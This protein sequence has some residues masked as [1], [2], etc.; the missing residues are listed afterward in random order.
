MTHEEAHAVAKRM[1]DVV[2]GNNARV[3]YLPH[4]L[5]EAGIDLEKLELD[6]LF[7]ILASLDA[8]LCTS[9]Y[10]KDLKQRIRF[11]APFTEWID[12]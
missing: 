1:I 4:L 9:K 6:E 8:E 2:Q 12:Y 3:P 7:R 11:A 10:P 5:A